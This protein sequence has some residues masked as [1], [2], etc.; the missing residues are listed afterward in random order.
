M[1]VVCNLSSW[2]VH[3]SS[4]S[5]GTVIAFSPLAEWCS[6]S[7][8]VLLRQ[9][10]PVP[11]VP[12]LI[13]FLSLRQQPLVAE[14]LDSS[15]SLPQLKGFLVAELPEVSVKEL[16]GLKAISPPGKLSEVLYLPSIKSKNNL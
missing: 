3:F 10:A 6:H 5:S 1:I 4:K 8:L 11:A 15:K 16:C 7:S 12:G 2:F 14:L 13:L 9:D